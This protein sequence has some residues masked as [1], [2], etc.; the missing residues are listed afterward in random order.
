MDKLFSNRNSQRVIF[1]DEEYRI[2]KNL[3]DLNKALVAIRM[4]PLEINYSDPISLKFPETY[5]APNLEKKLLRIKTT[6]E[7]LADLDTIYPENNLTMSEKEIKE[8]YSDKICES[9]FFRIIISFFDRETDGGDVEL[10]QQMFAESGILFIAI[11]KEF[12]TTKNTISIKYEDFYYSEDLGEI[13]RA[14]ETVAAGNL[15]PLIEKFYQK[16]LLYSKQ[17]K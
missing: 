3:I 13:I 9:L 7:I 6:E 12:K 2:I 16:L 14:M 11:S 1:S 8:H 4:P 15:N 17:N 10:I 5:Q